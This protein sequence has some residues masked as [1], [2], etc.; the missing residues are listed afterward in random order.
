M[1]MAGS[2]DD[3][4]KRKVAPK[5]EHVSSHKLPKKSDRVCLFCATTNTAE[6]RMGPDGTNSLC[7]ACGLRYANVKTMS[8]GQKTP[9]SKPRNLVPILPKNQNAAPVPPN[10]QNQTQQH[11]HTPAQSQQ[12]LPPASHPQHYPHYPH[13]QQFPQ[14]QHQPQQFPQHQQFS[15]HQHPQYQHQHPH[16]QPQHPF[17]LHQQQHHQTPNHLP[18][19]QLPL[20]LPLQ[21][22]QPLQ[23]QAPYGHYQSA[24]YPQQYSAQFDLVLPR[25]N[26]RP[27]DLT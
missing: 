7:N 11:P 18:S 26:K 10:P 14:H 15:Q 17:P 3:T 16:S 2:H 1:M 19:L 23:T 6:W 9:S 22:R 25:V 13:Q 27:L 12:H 24:Q 8:V 20:P 4:K 21:P 5:T